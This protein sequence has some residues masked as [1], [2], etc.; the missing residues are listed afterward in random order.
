MKDYI[1]HDKNS[2]TKLFKKD[3][4]SDGMYQIETKKS[5]DS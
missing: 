5:E 4:K 1:T 3:N 2:L